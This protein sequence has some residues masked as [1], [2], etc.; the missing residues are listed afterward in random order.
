M[1][2]KFIGHLFERLIDWLAVW[3]FI[4]RSIDWKLSLRRVETD[5]FVKSQPICFSS[6]YQLRTFIS[7]AVAHLR[8]EFGVQIRSADPNRPNI[9]IV[10]GPKESV[11]EAVKQLKERLT[12]MENERSRDIIIDRGLHKLIIGQKGQRIREIRD[13]FKE[14]NVAFPDPQEN[15]DVVTIRGPKEEVDKCFKYMEKLVKDLVRIWPKSNI[16]CIIGRMGWLKI[17]E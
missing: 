2:W 14:T 6:L 7:L 12:K 17:G 4:G 11:A 10:E 5:W 8:S 16:S 9:L 1:E 3:K 15:S 13:T